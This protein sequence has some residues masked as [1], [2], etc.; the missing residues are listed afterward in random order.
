M[1][2]DLANFSMLDLFRLEVENQATVLSDGLLAL[3]QD[4]QSEH[5]LE[6]LM[7]AAHS[8]K[9]AARMVDI[10]AGVKLAHAMED[11][12]V[13][14]QKGELHLH[15][16]RIDLLLKGVD[17]LI[18]ISR[19]EANADELEQLTHHI[20]QIDQL[21]ADQA[22]ALEAAA[23][24]V[25][26]PA[27]AMP[28]TQPPPGQEASLP[29]NDAPIATTPAAEPV[30][31]EKTSQDEAV[32]VSAESLNRLVGLAGEVRVESRWLHP[33]AETLLQIKNRQSELVGLLDKLNDNLHAGSSDEYNK[34]LGAEIQSKA[35]R[36]RHLLSDRLVELDEYDRRMHS[37]SNR[38]H[39]E[40]IASRMRPFA[41]VTRAYPRMVRDVARQLEKQVELKI[42]GLNTQVDRDILERIEAPLNHLLRNAID[43]GIES[44]EQ[45][46]EAGKSGQATLRLCALHNS[47]MLSIHVEDDGRGIDIERLRSSVV[48]K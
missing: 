20:L 23:A 41:D 30:S 43:H 38:L 15:T 5:Q 2:D 6:A 26:E 24:A 13:A 28:V 25:D 40:V 48:E 18:A 1:S 10:E 22:P 33:F 31:A 19:Q 35:N 37:L 17:Q 45:R 9:G 44:P 16:T 39:S 11:C 4:A 36:C 34:T 32:R 27:Q 7:R 14:A 12:F 21:E 42:E 46:I 8:V 29:D 47:G 3:E